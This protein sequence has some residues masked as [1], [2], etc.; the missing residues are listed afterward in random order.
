MGMTEIPTQNEGPTKS[1]LKKMV[2]SEKIVKIPE[3][4]QKPEQAAQPLSIKIPGNKG[5]QLLRLMSSF[6]FNMQKLKV[7]DFQTQQNFVRKMQLY[8]D[9]L[10]LNEKEFRTAHAESV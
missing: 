5:Q 10:A 3:Q 6:Q 2:S 4:T 7:W 8:F 9:W 1:K